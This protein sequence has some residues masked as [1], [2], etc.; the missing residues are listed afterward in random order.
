MVNVE[1]PFRIRYKVE[2][3]YDSTKLAEAL[4]GA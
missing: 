4:A 2:Q 1:Q 3:V